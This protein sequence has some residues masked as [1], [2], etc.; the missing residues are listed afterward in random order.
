MTRRPRLRQK[1]DIPGSMLSKRQ[2]TISRVCKHKGQAVFELAIF[3]AII[4]F[5]I[6]LIFSQAMSNSYFMNANFKAMRKAFWESYMASEQQVQSRD[7]ASV[8]IIEDRLMGKF[9]DKFSPLDRSPMV[10]SAS[11]TMTKMLFAERNFGEAN[12]IQIQDIIINGQR[13]PFSGAGYKSVTLP[14]SN[15][16]GSIPLCSAPHPEGRCWDIGCES[17]DLSALPVLED[18][19]NGEDEPGTDPAVDC[20]DPTCSGYWQCGGGLGNLGEDCGTPED[21]DLDG[22]INCADRDCLTQQACYLSMG[23]LRLYRLVENV[24]GT[25]FDPGVAARFDLDFDGTPD[26]PLADRADFAWQWV[27]INALCAS[28][29]GAVNVDSNFINADAGQPNGDRQAES[30]MS[31]GGCGDIDYNFDLVWL[32]GEDKRRITA[33]NVRDAQEGDMDGTRDD[34]SPPPDPGFVDDSQMF[35]YTR[36]GTLLRIEEGELFSL[37]DGRFV[38]NTTV[39]DHYDIVQRIFR[40]SND[41]NR[42]CSAAGTPQGSVDGLSNPVEACN[43]CFSPANLELT[44][45]DQAARLIYIRSRISNLGG[46]R[47]VTRKAPP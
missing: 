6:G 28:S 25:G 2:K 13:F 21:D 34:S 11:A 36:E 26:V 45:M 17:V 15:D 14:T 8:T 35:S 22:L 43:N 27:P 41:T 7:N 4:I 10:S 23:C 24:P 32:W 31:V 19:S 9:G 1:A 3:G 12:T 47:W 38:R 46:R 42:F 37:A 44:C 39:N 30:V 16:D 29:S 33:L 5:V 40:V 18:C 20:A